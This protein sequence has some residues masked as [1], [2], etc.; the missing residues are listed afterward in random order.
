[1]KMAT[2]ELE[3]SFLDINVW[4]VEN[5]LSSSPEESKAVILANRRSLLYLVV[6]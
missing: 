1:M 5:D 4:R 2:S 3:L 6:R